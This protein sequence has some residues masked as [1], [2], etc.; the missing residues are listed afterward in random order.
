MTMKRIKKENLNGFWG[1][2]RKG[3][4]SPL[5][6]YCVFANKGGGKTRGIKKPVRNT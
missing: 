3:S 2:E 6:L 4:L 5:S 1:V